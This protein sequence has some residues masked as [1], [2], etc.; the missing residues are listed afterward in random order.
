[1]AERVTARYGAD[2]SLLVDVTPPKGDPKRGASD[3]SIPRAISIGIVA[4]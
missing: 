1:M 4:I 2:A 3:K